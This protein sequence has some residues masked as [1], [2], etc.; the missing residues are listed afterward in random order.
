MF[1][2]KD[3]DLMSIVIYTN[4]ANLAID[5]AEIA[6]TKSLTAT[7][8]KLNPAIRL[9]AIPANQAA[10]IRPPISGFFSTINPATISMTPTIIIK[11]L[12]EN[13]KISASVGLIYCDQSVRILVNLSS[14]ATIGTTTK[15]YFNNWNVWLNVWFEVNVAMIL[16]YKINN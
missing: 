11:V 13:G 10:T 1:A 12:P 3:T 9:N 8:T 14:P 15:V 16:N 7:S 4:F 5:K 2:T 6:M